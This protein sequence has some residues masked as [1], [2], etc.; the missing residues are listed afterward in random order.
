MTLEF[1]K[2]R[3]FGRDRYFPMNRAAEAIL[4]ITGRK[5]LKQPE[6]DLLNFNGY[7]IVLVTDER[8][9]HGSPKD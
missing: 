3:E 6:I 2:R 1:I 8:N 7:Q 4:A 9:M 5:C